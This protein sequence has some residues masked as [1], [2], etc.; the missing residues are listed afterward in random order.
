MIGKPSPQIQQCRGCI[1]RVALTGR[2][3]HAAAAASRRRGD[4]CETDNPAPRRYVRLFDLEKD[5]GEFRNV[6]KE[7]PRMVMDPERLA[8]E[9]MRATHPEA[10]LEPPA[11]SVED[12]LDFCLPPRDA[13]PQA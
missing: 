5:S 3:F 10:A 8:L 6:A 12:R 4:R 9:R 1:I 7:P 13:R 11:G 2:A